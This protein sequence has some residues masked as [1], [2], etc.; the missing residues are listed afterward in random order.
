MK[1]DVVILDSCKKEL[2]NFPENILQDLL[3]VI[4]K[5][6]EGL[7]L[8]MPLCRSMPNID[9]G[10]YELRFKEKNNIYRIFYI[11]KKKDAIYIVH[12]FQ[13]KTQKTPKKNIELVKKRIQRSI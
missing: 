6:K 8:S 13:K 3:D 11:I 2:T 12:A 9:K 1:L 4:A 5:L 10:V 7:I